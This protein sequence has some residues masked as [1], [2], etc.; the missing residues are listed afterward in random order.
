MDEYSKIENAEDFVVY[1]A[2][3]WFND[4]QM[5]CMTRLYNFLLDCSFTV[6]SP[7]YSGIVVN[8]DNDS[9]EIRDMAYEWNLDAIQK[10]TIVL[11]VVDDWDPGTVFEMGYAVGMQEW[12]E[13]NGLPDIISYSDVTGRG[14]NLML[15]KASYA[16]ANGMDELYEQLKRY[17]NAEPPLDTLPYKKGDVI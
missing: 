16:F 9:P 12:D 10:S 14:L 13:L 11:A 2:S 5:E 1:L 6:H 3:G 7:Y 4:Q 15:Q 17:V 8:K